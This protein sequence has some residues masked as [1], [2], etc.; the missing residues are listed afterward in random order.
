MKK[1]FIFLLFAATGLGT[2]HAQVEVWGFAGAN[3]SKANFSDSIIMNEKYEANFSAGISLRKAGEGRISFLTDLAF[4]PKGYSYSYSIPFEQ[5]IRLRYFYLD[6]APQ[7]QY[8]LTNVLS[9]SAGPYGSLKL[10][11]RINAGDGWKKPLSVVGEFRDDTDFGFIAVARASL[12]QFT[13]ALS[14]LHG[15]QN[16]S[17]IN[18]T[19]ENGVPIGKTY[20]R[21]RAV[22]LTLGYRL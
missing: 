15:L 14:Y 3:I 17:D 18:F 8:R 1:L 11:E 16:V 5:K 22:Q 4:A 6:L 10:K 19:D 12:G 20:E 13:L 2:L 7:L 9:I 21:N